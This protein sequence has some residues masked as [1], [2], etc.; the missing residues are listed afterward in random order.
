MA[1]RNIQ[2][3]DGQWQP[4]T[5]VLE[6]LDEGLVDEFLASRGWEEFF[7]IGGEFAL[8]ICSY[9]LIPEDGSQPEYLIQVEDGSSISHFVKVTSIVDLMDLFARWA[10]AVQAATVA[11][12][13]ADITN[14]D[15]SRFGNVERIAAKAAYGIDSVL[16]DLK[17][18]MRERQSAARRQREAR[19]A[20]AG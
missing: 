15:L 6:D 7:T 2:L 4:M 20:K 14:D 9:R 18:A 3:I 10:P 11:D 8:R 12:F 19:S 5:D 16:P 13:L 17:T 1:T